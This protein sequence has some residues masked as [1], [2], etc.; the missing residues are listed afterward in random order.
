MRKRLILS[1][2]WAGLFASALVLVF[3]AE[4]A[5]AQEFPS[6]FVTFYVGTPPGSALDVITRAISSSLASI[7]SVPV[8]VENKPG[9]GTI[10][11]AM[12]VARAK[13]DGY[14]VALTS[15][16]IFISKALNKNLGFDPAVD[17]TPV[18]LTAVSP[19]VLVVHPS[20][21][22]RQRSRGRF[23]LRSQIWAASPRRSRPAKCGLLP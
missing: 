19:F 20:L 16:A 17:I 12:Q 22:C 6:K 7:W 1:L 5:R 14:S 18:S 10:L 8:I 4:A 13:P 21:R 11:S 9:A 3:L 15:T 23:N 2:N